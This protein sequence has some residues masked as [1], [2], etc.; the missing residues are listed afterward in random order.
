MLMVTTVA[1]Y[2]ALIPREQIAGQAECEHEQQQHDAG[3]PRDFPRT[4]VRA[5]KQHAQQMQHREDHDETGA[6]KMQP[7]QHAAELELRHDETQALVRVR[8]HRHVVHRQRDAGDEL[9]R[10]Q[11][12]Q[13]AAEREEPVH[14][15]RN[16]F[17][18][19]APQARA[20]SGAIVEPVAEGHQ[21]WT[22]TFELSTRAAISGS[23]R[24]GGPETLRPSGREHAT[25]ARAL[26]QLALG[27]VADAAPKMGTG[28]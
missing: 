8:R 4:F 5:E 1:Q 21:S 11:K 28:R 25:M 26:D 13:H 24:G 9:Q 3:R 2:R 14:V 7:P 19:N 15:T 12:Q 23:G 22:K 17:V 10:Q 27:I 20:I 6:E 16:G 18:E